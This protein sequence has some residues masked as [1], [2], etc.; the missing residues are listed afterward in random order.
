MPIP[1]VHFWPPEVK[2]EV[3][4][5][6]WEFQRG[7]C[8]YCLCQMVQVD[9]TPKKKRDATLDHVVPTSK[10][11]GKLHVWNLVLSCNYCNHTKGDRIWR[12]KLGIAYGHVDFPDEAIDHYDCCD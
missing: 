8:A 5:I 7:R 2:R 11:G 3:T 6:I 12:P 1:Y 4:R 10:G 9:G